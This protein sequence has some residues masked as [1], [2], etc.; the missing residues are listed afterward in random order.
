MQSV[1]LPPFHPCSLV[2]VLV[3]CG[4]EGGLSEVCVGVVWVWCGCGVGVCVCGCGYGCVCAGFLD[5]GLFLY[6]R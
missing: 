2:L 6:D 4:R 5:F 1:G 3:L